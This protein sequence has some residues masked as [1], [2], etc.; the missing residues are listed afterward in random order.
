[1]TARRKVPAAAVAELNE[2]AVSNDGLLTPVVVLERA[3]NPAS[4]LHPLFTWDDARAGHLRRLD[5]ARGIIMSVRVIIAPQPE[6]PVMNVRAFTSLAADRVSGG[7]YRQMQVVMSRPDLRA[8]LLRTAIQELAAL[9]KKYATLQELAQ[10]FAALDEAQRT[11][12]S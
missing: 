10:V 9:Q 6:R 4:A 5:E 2:L 11:A 8:Q 3:S 1:M 12:A 7:G